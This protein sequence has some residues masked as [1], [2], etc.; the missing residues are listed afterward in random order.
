MTTDAEPTKAPFWELFAQWHTLIDRGDPRFAMLSTVEEVAGPLAEIEAGVT[1]NLWNMQRHWTIHTIRS[2]ADLNDNL[3]RK[4][5]DLRLVLP[6]R[7][8]ER[9]CPL[10]SSHHPHLRLFPVAHPLMVC[11]RRLVVVGDSTGDSVWCTTEPGLV[12]R[13]VEFFQEVWH[14]AVPAVATGE[15]PPFT[16]RMVEIALLLV[17]GATD[18]EIARSLGVSERTVSA[19]VR[20]LSSRLGARSRAQ[21]IALISGVDG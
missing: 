21:A 4:G 5:V 20:E 2:N 8:A 7:V 11:D 3:R 15:T 13:A 14:R 6:R 1:S 9:R 10:A 16:A 17:D 12:G 18:R 19:D